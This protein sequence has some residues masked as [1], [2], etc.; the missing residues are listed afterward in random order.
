MKR[1]P[2]LDKRYTAD[3]AGTDAT[4]ATEGT[5]APLGPSAAPGA[6]GTAMATRGGGAAVT[7]GM[8]AGPFFGAYGSFDMHFFFELSTPSSTPPRAV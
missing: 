8:M 6:P 3:T 1:Y 7:T 4:D 5:A 2:G